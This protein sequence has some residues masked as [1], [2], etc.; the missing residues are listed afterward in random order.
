MTLPDIVSYILA[1]SVLALLG[2]WAIL[3]VSYTLLFTLEVGKFMIGRRTVSLQAL[4]V[5]LVVGMLGVITVFVG[6]VV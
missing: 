4:L 1:G 5:G 6:V 2:F 3:M